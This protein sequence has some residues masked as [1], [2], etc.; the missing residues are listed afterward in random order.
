[1]ILCFP[2]YLS[3]FTMRIYIQNI[4]TS[5]MDYTLHVEP[6]DTVVVLKEKLQTL[7]NTP[8]TEYRIIH[9]NHLLQNKKTIGDYG[10][11]EDD[12]LYVLEQSIKQYSSMIL[13]LQK[14][15]TPDD[16]FI[17]VPDTIDDYYNIFF[18]QRSIGNGQIIRM[19]R[20]KMSEYMTTV[21]QTI[22]FDFNGCSHIQIDFPGFPSIIV[23]RSD[24]LSY[25]ELFQKQLSILE[26]DWPVEFYDETL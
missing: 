6:S 24:I 5:Y 25:F 20:S 9:S 16:V 26:E 4:A 3:P 10:I 7:F 18:I 12:I 23:Q 1:M 14:K 8:H 21:F 2:T 15:V 13:T 22:A 11:H 17:I 19:K